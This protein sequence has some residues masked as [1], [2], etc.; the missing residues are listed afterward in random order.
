MSHGLMTVVDT[1]QKTVLG[2]ANPLIETIQSK[3]VQR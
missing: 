2:S 3:E 1:I